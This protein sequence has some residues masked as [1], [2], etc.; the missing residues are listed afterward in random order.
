MS[1]TSTRGAARRGPARRSPGTRIAAIAVAAAVA[2]LAAAC[3]NAAPSP[4]AAGSTGPG[5][6]ATIGPSATPAPAPT[7]APSVD[8]S[9]LY[10]EIEDQVIA[11]RGLP[12]KQRIEPTILSEAEARARIAAD[13]RATYPPETI[14]TSE[15][16]LKALGLLPADAS[17]DSLY[18]DLMSS[19]AVAFYEPK[20]KQIFVISRSG[21]SAAAEKVY[22]SHE[23]THALQDQNFGPQGTDTNVPGQADRSLARLSL[24]EGDAVLLMTQW[25]SRHLTVAELGQLLQVDPAAQAQLATMPAIL[26][27][28]LMFPYQQGLAFVSGIWARGGWDAVNAV[29]GRLPDSTEQI[30][31][32]E[33]YQAG[34]KPVA[35]PLAAA[36]LAKAMGAGWSG[37]PEDTLGEFQLSVWLGQNGV[38]A[39]D[40]Q[41]AAAG[42]G[43]DRYAYLRGP[44]G[45]YALALLTAWDTQADADEFLAAARTAAANLPGSADVRVLRP[46]EGATVGTVAVLVASD[47][48]AL[49]SL[50][51]AVSRG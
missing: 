24:L 16:T 13:Y 40:A 19:Q 35:V 27:D 48:A 30:L 28:T 36:T 22:F 23:Y 14:A 39:P 9:T 7:P 21:S 10:R 45:S 34:E 47:T 31:H 12:A 38:K 50:A 32:P 25:M 26:R 42:W 37:T 43:G 3:S 4:S 44:N 20:A 15:A 51:R 6:S 41:A 5:P 18:I 11:L 49:G 29:Y 46:I 1:A 33:K 17:L 8:A 2:L